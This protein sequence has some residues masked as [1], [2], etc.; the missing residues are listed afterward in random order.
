MKII[1][2]ALGILVSAFGTLEADDENIFKL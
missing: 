1:F 2:N